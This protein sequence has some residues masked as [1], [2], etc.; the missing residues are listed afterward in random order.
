MLSFKSII[1]KASLYALGFT[2]IFTSCNSD[3]DTS[4]VN[5]MDIASGTSVAFVYS[6]QKLQDFFLQP[7]KAYVSGYFY[8]EEDL[9]DDIIFGLD[10]EWLEGVDNPL[11]FEGADWMS[12]VGITRKGI[13][14]FPVGSSEI[15]QGT[16]SADLSWEIRDLGFDLSPNNWYKMIIECDF[17][18][19][20]FKSVKIEGNG[21]NITEDIS[22]FLLEYPNFAP[23]DKPSLTFYTFAIRSKEFAPDNNG[24]TKVYFDDIEGGISVGNSFETVFSNGFEN[25]SQIIDIPVTLPTIKLDDVN[26]NFW[27]FENDIAKIKINSI[28]SNNGSKSI[29]CDAT[30]VAQ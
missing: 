11:H 18:K 24:G 27:Y 6:D 17:D 14:W 3:N 20:E 30:L 10:I 12:L 19:R 9:A 7:D 16:P 5:L 13:L 29:E 26:E 21:I 23:F 22:G 25:Q 1:N 15:F 28:H 8:F 2:T 4:E